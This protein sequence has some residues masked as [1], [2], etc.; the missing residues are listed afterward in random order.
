LAQPACTRECV[1][2]HLVAMRVQRATL[3]D[4]GCHCTVVASDS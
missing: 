3:T 2:Q 1:A 4:A